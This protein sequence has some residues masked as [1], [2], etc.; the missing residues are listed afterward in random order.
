VTDGALGI[1][2]DRTVR[3]PAE[4]SVGRGWVDH[5]ATGIPPSRVRM[6]KAYFEPGSRTSWHRHWNGQ[7]LHVTDGHLVVQERGSP[8]IA[9]GPGG[10]VSCTPDVWHWHGSDADHMLVVVA[11]V[12]LDDNGHEAE[13]GEPVTDEEYAQALRST[14]S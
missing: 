7:I 4:I 11:V 3:V 2:A 6:I 9:I 5:I 8:A 13:W 1:S 12:E 10:S 14:F